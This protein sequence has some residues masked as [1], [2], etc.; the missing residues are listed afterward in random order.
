MPAAPSGYL[1][2]DGREVSRATYAALF[3]AIGTYWGAGNGVDTFKLPDM[4]GE[5]RRGWDNG[6]GV[7][8]GR[9]FASAQADAFRAHSHQIVG[10]DADTG[11]QDLA[12]HIDD[13]G[14]EGRVD[15]TE[16]T[17]GSETR[18]RNIAVLTCIKF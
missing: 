15:T 7:D 6:R 17:G 14:K 2:C 12:V 4:R 1:A 8:R 11:G 10:N 18:P 5:F 9:A 3:N 13:D 16:V